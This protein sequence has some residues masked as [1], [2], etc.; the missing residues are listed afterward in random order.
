M[1]NGNMEEGKSFDR[2]SMRERQIMD[3]VYRFGRATAAEIRKSLPDPPSYSATRAL[4]G[5]L[6]DKGFLK[7]EKQGR[8]YIYIPIVSREDAGRSA[9]SHL[10]HTFF[11]GSVES[12]IASLVRESD[13]KLTEEELR[14]I[15][16]LIREKRDGS[17]SE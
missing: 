10:V 17:K 8:R 1:K 13:V 12:A 7:H 4:L 9:V 3:A 15:E 2:L 14:R 5:I 6:E 16:D 11:N